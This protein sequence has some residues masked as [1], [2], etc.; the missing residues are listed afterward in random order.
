VLTADENFKLTTAERSKSPAANPKKTGQF[1]AV[2]PGELARLKSSDKH[3]ELGS[4]LRKLA[5][6]DL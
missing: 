6:I 3:R 1:R 5:R 4:G 2:P